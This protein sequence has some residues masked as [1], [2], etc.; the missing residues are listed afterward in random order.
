MFRNVFHALVKADGLKSPQKKV[1]H[2]SIHIRVDSSLLQYGI[3]G[4]QQ[5]I[6]KGFLVIFP[7]LVKRQVIDDHRVELA[8]FQ[9]NRIGKINMIEIMRFEKLFLLFFSQ[10][11]G[12]KHR[13][14]QRDKMRSHRF[15]VI[16]GK[17][18]GSLADLVA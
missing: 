9:Q 12:G 18:P 3:H 10:A 13:I 17:F 2:R 8:C 11:C 5:V 14:L 6:F 7:V 1:N 16:A 4:H 15:R